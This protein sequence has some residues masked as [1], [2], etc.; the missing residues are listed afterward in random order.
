VL[1]DWV[2]WMAQ[3]GVVPSEMRDL[4]IPVVPADLAMKHML[5]LSQA[6]GALGKR[7]GVGEGKGKGKPEKIRIKMIMVV[8]VRSR[9]PG[10]DASRFRP[11][12]VV[13]LELGWTSG[14]EQANG[15]SRD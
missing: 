3:S 15:A 14:G 8:M 5:R 9:G 6:P 10:G 1:L 2:A 4:L 7:G 13:P 11:Q 12:G